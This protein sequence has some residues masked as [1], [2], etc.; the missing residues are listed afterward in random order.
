MGPEHAN[1]PESGVAELS[2]IVLG[3]CGLGEQWQ[4]N[5]EPCTLDPGNKEGAG[6]NKEGTTN[7]ETQ[8]W[9]GASGR[10]RATVQKPVHFKDSK[11]VKKKKKLI[12]V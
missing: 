10:A 2:W 8:P 5:Q 6:G 1:F 3:A 4:L 7:T 11:K 9:P 12:F